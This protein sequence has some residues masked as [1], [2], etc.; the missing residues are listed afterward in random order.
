MIM[1]Y[2]P[3][4]MAEE[5]EKESPFFI[6]LY[7]LE[8]RTGTSYIAAADE[9]ITIGD[10]V[11]TAIPFSRD[12]IT[13]STDNLFD[14]TEVKLGDVD[15]SR[16]SYV[17]SGFDF[18]GCVVTIFKIQYPDTLENP[19]LII[20][21]FRGYLDSP[22]YESGVFS[23]KVK[24]L[25]PTVE[26][27]QRT[28]QNQCNSIFGDENCTLD[29]GMETCRVVGMAG[30]ILQLERSFPD[31][32]WTNGMAIINGESRNIKESA[33]EYI[34]T[35]INFLQDG[36]VGANIRLERGCDKTKECCAAHKNLSHFGGFPAIPFEA[37][38]RGQ[39]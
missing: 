20:P 37:Q 19:N 23:C 26:V 12:D 29:R 32:Y 13:R 16:L 27:P 8:L 4:K 39:S 5:K 3:V 1:S 38:Y 35:G 22:T 14:E 15:S 9:D 25:F 17:M 18:R 24:S 2:V 6:E 11:F 34:T 33:G 21:V 10:T 31:G 7:V 36:V 30:N 28:F